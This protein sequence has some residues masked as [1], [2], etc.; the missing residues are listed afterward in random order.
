[1]SIVI[2]HLWAVWWWRNTLPTQNPNNLRVSLCSIPKLDNATKDTLRNEAELLY[3]SAIESK[4]PRYL[5]LEFIV[6]GNIVLWGGRHMK[7]HQWNGFVPM[8]SLCRTNSSN[9]LVCSPEFT[10]LLVA[11]SIKQL[12]PEKLEEWQNVVI[13]AEL[14][15]EL[16]GTYSKQL[17]SNPGFKQRRVCLTCIGSIAQ[18][19]GRMAHEHGAQRLG[20]V[21]P[22][23][24]DNLNSPM[25]T[26]LYLLLCLPKRFGGM[27]LPKPFANT[28]LEVPTHLRKKTHLAHII[29]DLLW[30][31]AMLIVEYDGAGP[32]AGH[33]KEDQERQEL[34]Q[35]MNYRLITFR[36]EDL[37]D[38][39]KFRAKAES[40]ARYLGRE[41]PPASDQFDALQ[42]T[43]RNMLI[44]HERWL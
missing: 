40:V 39:T 29:P 32:H 14:G 33:E 35:D 5:P 3:E 4:I 24:L 26:V 31:E 38:K 10:L 19:L 34:A 13:I 27:A 41:L 20:R 9:H 43:L 2:S 28:P 8:W 12:L 42:S 18:F 36:I 6:S 16:C 30:P 44:N 7:Q 23:I 15:C 11:G 17:I 1:M 22:W 37:K 21:L 25:E